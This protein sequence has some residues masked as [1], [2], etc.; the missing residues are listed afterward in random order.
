MS[1][2]N[3]LEIPGWMEP[4]SLIWL[5]AQA[6]QSR[7]W[8]EIGCLCGRSTVAVANGLPRGARLTV[9]DPFLPVPEC[10]RLDAKDTK[11]PRQY[12]RDTMIMIRRERPDLEFGFLEC[13]SWEAKEKIPP[14]FDAVFLDGDH[15]EPVVKAEILWLW[16]LL[17]EGGLMSG[18]DY[19]H[20][21]YPGVKIAVD[22][23]CGQPHQV[24][25]TSVWWI[26][27]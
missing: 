14:W 27:K 12:W 23:F 10:W 8:L 13:R 9:V 1:S 7:S 5:E 21:D 24:P 26:R 4:I 17:A 16:P 22:Q 20:K 11:T 18:H 6:K 15:T 2:M 3:P 19:T 25:D